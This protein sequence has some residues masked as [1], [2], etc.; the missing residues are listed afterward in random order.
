MRSFLPASAACKMRAWQL[1]LFKLS[2]HD[3]SATLFSLSFCLSLPGLLVLSLYQSVLVVFSKKS[4]LN[5][6][7]FALALCLVS[8]HSIH[9]LPGKDK[10]P[11]SGFASDRINRATSSLVNVVLFLCL[12]SFLRALIRRSC[13]L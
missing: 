11:V 4:P 10:L 6:L 5:S 1:N 2:F 13:R 12:K 7:A 9:I 3:Q 8:L